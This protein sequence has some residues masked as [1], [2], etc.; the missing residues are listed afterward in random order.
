L[1]HADFKAENPSIKSFS[2]VNVPFFVMRIT[3]GADVT[4]LTA[5]EE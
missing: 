4:L 5:G 3:P 1:E 2:C